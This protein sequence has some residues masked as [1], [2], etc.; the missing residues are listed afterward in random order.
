MTPLKVKSLG[1]TDRYGWSAL[2]G[3]FRRTDGVYGSLGEEAY[4]WTTTEKNFDS[5]RVQSI[6]WDSVDSYYNHLRYISG[7]Y[8]GNGESV[9]CV[10][11]D[12]SAKRFTVTFNAGWG[13]PGVIDAMT[14]DSG[15]TLGNAMPA[16]TRPGY[17]FRYWKADSGYY[18]Y[19]ANFTPITGNVTF[20]AVWGKPVDVY[21]NTDG[22]TPSEIRSIQV[23]SGSC[24]TELPPEPVKAGHAFVGWFYNNAEYKHDVGVIVA[25]IT[26]TARWVAVPTYTVTLDFYG[27]ATADDEHIAIDSGKSLGSMMPDNPAMPGYFFEG[28]FDGEKRYDSK[29]VISGDVVLTARWRQ[30]PSYTVSFNTDGGTPASVAAVQVDSGSTL[31]GKMPAAPSKTGFHF[32]G[33]YDGDAQYG[34]KTPVVRDVTL[35]ARWNAKPKYT[36]S[37]NTNGGVPATLAPAEVDSG[38]ALGSNMPAA[39]TR[40]GYFFTGWF[41]GAA[42]YTATAPQIVTSVTLTAQWR[43]VPKYTVSF[44]TN[45]GVPSSL[46]SAQVDSGSTLGDRMPDNP[47]KSGYNFGGWYDGETRYTAGTV[48]T[49]TVAL[50]ARWSALPVYTVSFHGNGIAAGTAPSSQ[51]SDSGKTITLPDQGSM[52]VTMKSFGGW[53]T[54]SDG[55]GTN[56]NGGSSYTVRANIT[57]YAV[58]KPVV[59]TYFEDDRDG[60]TYGAVKIGKQTWMSE[61]LNYDAVGNSWCYGDDEDSC[62]KYGRLYSW[63]A[64]MDGYGSSVANPSGVQ[65]IC[66]NGWHLPSNAEWDALVTAAGGTYDAGYKLKSTTGWNNYNNGLDV[67]GFSALPGGYRYFDGKFYSAGNNGN[68][69]T[70]TAYSNAYFRSMS[71]GYGVG[72]SNGDK[73]YGYSVRCVQD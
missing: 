11:D 8:K 53:N 54:K 49:K 29:T 24:L 51:S 16:V 43:A 65:G 17:N 42:Q 63:E 52:L 20:T 1:G 25:S 41:D 7:V 35:K 71:S 40:S 45:G 32:A 3:G 19:D 15:K 57:L 66:P 36:V 61:N 23:D 37:F 21:F 58:W 18:N 70:A 13:A 34:D 60:K 64:A 72:E 9:R 5:A 14:I 68:W 55:T 39:P 30:V 22:G 48:I 50:T 2:P 31:V 56:Y 59:V 67:Y 46:G 62:G 38:S 28:W 10:Q 44:N 27:G 47:T 69:W 12:G 6:E 26:L 73:S 4:W 33:W